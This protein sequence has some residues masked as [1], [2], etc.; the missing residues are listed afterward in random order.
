MIRKYNTLHAFCIKIKLLLC[1]KY[2]D[3]CELRLK[4]CITWLLIIIELKLELRYVYCTN[5][6]L[7]IISHYSLL[8][9]TLVFVF[10]KNE[11]N[12]T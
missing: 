2:A 9:I 8:F 5:T 3:V 11:L 10:L 1:K 4:Q 7:S 6:R 12:D